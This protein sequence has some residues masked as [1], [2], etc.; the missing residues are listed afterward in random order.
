MGRCMREL[1]KRKLFFWFLIPLSGRGR[2]AMIHSHICRIV[3]LGYFTFQT[4]MLMIITARIKTI[5][6][7]G[8]M[9][10]IRRAVF[11]ETGGG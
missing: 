1:S 7:T 9:I 8:R 10:P 11:E 4:I 5:S 6:E 2:F 3:D